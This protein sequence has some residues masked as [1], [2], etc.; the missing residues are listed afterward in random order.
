MNSRKDR[1][2]EPTEEHD[3]PLLQV[4]VLTRSERSRRDERPEGGETTESAGKE[5]VRLGLCRLAESVPLDD[6]REERQRNPETSQ[7]T[8]N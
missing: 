7:P 3:I 2:Q 5:G 1:S 4:L 6:A 8:V